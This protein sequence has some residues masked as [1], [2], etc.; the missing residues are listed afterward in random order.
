MIKLTYFGHSCFLISIG[1]KDLL[2]D[3][4]F[5]GNP[6]APKSADEVSADVILVT[7]GHGDHLGDTVKIAQRC[8]SLVIS[9]FEIVTYLQREGVENVHPMHIGGGKQFDF[10]RV[11]L[12]PAFHGSSLI[13]NTI[14]CGGMPAGFLLELDGKVIYH[15]GD[16]GLTIE[17]EL[18]GRLNSI[19]IALLPIGGNF[20]MDAKD[21]SEAVKLLKPKKVV[22]MHYNTWAPI[23]ANPEEFKKLVGN[24]AEVIILKPGESVEI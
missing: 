14:E 12:T 4:F 11:K 15:A 13:G 7:H 1:K 2:I 10:G 17:M 18:L 3:P 6:L 19:D 21:A 8:K 22:P 23:E 5:E 20:T 16:T 24:N 9:N